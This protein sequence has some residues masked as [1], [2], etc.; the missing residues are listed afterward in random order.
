MTHDVFISH[1]SLDKVAADAVCHGLETHGVRCW[2]APRDQVAGKPYGV[3]IA[4]AIREAQ[5][6][7]LVF[8]DNVNRSQAVLNE[9]N[10]AAQAN[11]TIVPFRIAAVEFNPELD[12]YL[13]RTHWLDAFPRPVQSYIEALATTVRRNLSAPGAAGPPPVTPAAP[14]AAPRRLGGSRIVFIGAAAVGG[15]VVVLLATIVV[16]ALRGQSSTAALMSAQAAADTTPIRPSNPQQVA[17]FENVVAPGGPP[18]T[19]PGV[20]VVSTAQ[21]VDRI[22]AHDAGQI[23]LWLIDARGCS[24][25]PTLPTAD[26]MVPNTIDQIRSEIPS[27]TMELIFFTLDGS[28]SE[29]YQAAQA[30]IAAGYT[31]VLW[32]RGGV[33]AWSA[34]GLPTV[35]HT[36]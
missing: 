31:D 33:N 30:A 20:T 15:L 34:A 2:I 29:A 12:Y 1:S 11:V 16:L 24:T 25:Q 17:T 5:V 14:A 32:Y 8:S 18:L 6:M 22:K 10:I 9:I 28:R 3:Q 19:L 35:S 23:H 4:Q 36:S 13:G 7:V 26:C 27:K 21:M